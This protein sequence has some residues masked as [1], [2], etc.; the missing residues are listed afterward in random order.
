MR[1]TPRPACSARCVR[2]I[3]RHAD[4]RELASS[5]K[6][7]ALRLRRYRDFIEADPAAPIDLAALA[8]LASVTRFQVIRDF[9]R[10]G[11]GLTPGAYIRRCRLRAA[12]QFIEQGLPLADAAAAAGFADQSHLSRVFHSIHGITPLMFRA[13]CA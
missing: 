3:R 9:K 10:Q 6:A 7:C 8:R 11:T 13:A 5:V 12:R 2:L 1:S 4:R